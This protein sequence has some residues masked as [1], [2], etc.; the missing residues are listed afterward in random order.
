MNCQNFETHAAELARGALVEASAR[1]AARAHADACT[2]C[3]ARLA[4]ER[5]LSAGLRA[6]ADTARAS[7]APAR[8]EA[9]LL[10]SF[11]ARAWNDDAPTRPSV[12]AVRAFDVKRDAPPSAL[13][14]FPR[15]AQGAA[16]AA[17]SALLVVG[18]YAL[19][20][21]RRAGQQAAPQH[22]SAPQQHNPPHAAQPET[23]AAQQNSA[24]LSTTG[25]AGGGGDENQKTT[26]ALHNERMHRRAGGV[27]PVEAKFG[28]A[29]NV[30]S[31]AVTSA[32]QTLNNAGAADEE[33]ATDFI[34]LVHNQLA[35]AESGRLVR[36]ELPRSALARFGLPVNAERAGERVKADVLIGDDGIARAI[37]FVR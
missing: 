19:A 26:A 24:T 8:V 17:A 11:R 34:P 35:P 3:A 23:T 22:A 9:A 20:A 1:D 12:E 7:E 29:R 28:G 5:A 2:L 32:G 4:D 16:V 13:R 6:F 33:I 36:V 15:W 30:A 21:S 18:L 31:S 37:R 14:W 10:A 27:R 25:Q